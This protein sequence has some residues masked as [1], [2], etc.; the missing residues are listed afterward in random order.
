MAAQ[1]GR[2][3]TRTVVHSFARGDLTVRFEPLGTSVPGFTHRVLLI[4][5]RTLVATD[6]L[7]RGVRPSGRTAAFYADGHGCLAAEEGQT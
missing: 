7:G 2:G 3:W 5:D 1:T 4:R 6:W